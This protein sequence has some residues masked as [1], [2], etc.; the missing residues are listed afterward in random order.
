MTGIVLTEFTRTVNLRHFFVPR[1]VV[2]RSMLGK[3][4]GFDCNDNPVIALFQRYS[5]V[6]YVIADSRPNSI[7]V[8]KG[9]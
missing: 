6:F 9:R 5:S 7:L 4:L 8:P 3:M 1:E 2:P